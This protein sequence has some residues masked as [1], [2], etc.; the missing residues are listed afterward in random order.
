MSKT[1][2]SAVETLGDLRRHR[3]GL[4]GH[5]DHFDCSNSV[6]LDLDALI[7]RLGENFVFINDVRI[8]A[9]LRC[10]QC[11][12]KGGSTRIEADT[13]SWIEKARDDG[14]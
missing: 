6:V 7:D 5:C 9:S 8:G 12:R 13:R 10:K 3:M 4:V 2:D 14:A 1:S 11:G